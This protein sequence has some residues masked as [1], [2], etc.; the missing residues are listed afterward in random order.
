MH[1]SI[2]V[3]KIASIFSKE[4]IINPKAKGMVMHIVALFKVV[5]LEILY[6]S[7]LEYYFVRKKDKSS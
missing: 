7:Y 6:G 1:H 2:I 3:A 4:R 5:L